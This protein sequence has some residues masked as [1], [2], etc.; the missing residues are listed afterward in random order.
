VN[1]RLR[2]QR[3]QDPDDDRPGDA[4]G[5]QLLG[6]LHDRR[7]HQH[8]GQQQQPEEERE[9]DFADEIAV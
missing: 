6:V 5:N 2:H 3:Q 9:Q 1:E 4:F 8:E 7:H